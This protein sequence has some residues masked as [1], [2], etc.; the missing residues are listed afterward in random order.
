LGNGFALGSIEGRVAF[1]YVG[2]KDASK[3]YSFK[4]HRKDRAPKDQSMI[5]AVNDISFHPVTGIFST[6]GSDGT[7]HFWDKDAR[8]RLKT[9][10]QVQ[11][12]VI[13][14]A[15]NHTGSMFAYAVSYDW[16]KGHTGMTPDLPNKIFL[17]KCKEE[18]VRKRPLRT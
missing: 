10:D 7:I 8:M 3:N 17:H 5:Y 6:C 14:T 15:F 1:Q 18:E 9:F 4:C 16:S 11:G 12:P 2:E 13:A